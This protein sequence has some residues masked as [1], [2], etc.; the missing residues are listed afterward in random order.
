MPIVVVGSKSDLT[1]QYELDPE[2]IKMTVE[3][4]HLPLYKTSA[5][6]NENIVDV[7]EGLARQYRF[8]HNRHV[9][10]EPTPLTPSKRSPQCI[11]M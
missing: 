5:K 7:F 6:N 4:W 3:E 11:I 8:L 1:R 9:N 2:Q 10:S